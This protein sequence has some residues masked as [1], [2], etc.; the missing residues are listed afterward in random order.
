MAIDDVFPY[1]ISHWA[2]FRDE[3]VCRRVRAIRKEQICTH[4]NPKLKIELVKDG[5]IA[6]FRIHD[7]F[8]R[9]KEAME[10]GRTF[11][12]ILPQPHPQYIKVA[13][14]LNRFRVNCRNL[15]TFNMDE[16]ADQDGNTAP[17]T[18]KNGFLHAQ[19]SN[20]YSRLDRDLRP[21]LDHIHGLT[22]RNIKD[23]GRMIADLGG[24]DVCYGG[25]GWSGHIAFIDPDTPEFG[26]ESIEEF[27]QMGPRIV[28]L[29]H[30]TI[31]QSSI[32]ADFGMGGD[33]SWIPPRAATIGPMEILG[34]KVRSSWNYFKLADTRISWQ[35][36]SVRLALHGPITP[37]VP[38]SILQF[39]PSEIHISETVAEDIEP[40][41]DASWY[42]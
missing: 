22:N 36:F 7:I 6:F 27:K 3:E 1:G 21:P 10:N 23:Y 15:H 24:A 18:Y 4:P 39:G 12:M 25:I 14:L 29:N 40:N 32:D 33:W 35:R 9:I 38:A 28:T 30:F 13:W 20:F 42:T 19:L 26:T 11:V 2:P 31:A 5:D 41:W 16:W 37:R 17:E 8:F 34:A